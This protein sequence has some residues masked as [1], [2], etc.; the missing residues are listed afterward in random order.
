MI[1]E[2]TPLGRSHLLRCHGAV[3][4][5]SGWYCSGV[6]LADVRTPLQLSVV[7]RLVALSSWRAPPAVRGP[8]RAAWARRWFSAALQQAIRPDGTGPSTCCAGPA[9][10]RVRICPQ[11]GVRH[12][13]LV[14]EDWACSVQCAELTVPPITYPHGPTRG[15]FSTVLGGKAVR[16]P[17]PRARPASPVCA[18][19]AYQREQEVMH[20]GLEVGPQGGFGERPQSAEQVFAISMMSACISAYVL[21]WSALLA[22]AAARA[23]ATSLLSLP[24]SGADNV[25][26]DPPLLSDLLAEPSASPPF[27]SRMP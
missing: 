22:F 11:A 6:K 25:D 12:C 13:R 24:L 20:T 1:Y 17:E 16:G 5:S 7:R 8:A 9:Q 4:A 3:A 23:F 18:I 27:A 19:S 26:G 14:W 10:S 15:P 21:R 2:T